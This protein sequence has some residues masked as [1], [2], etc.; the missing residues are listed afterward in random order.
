MSTTESPITYPEHHAAWLDAMGV[1]RWHSTH[2]IEPINVEISAP[3]SAIEVIKPITAPVKNTLPALIEHASYWVVGTEALD[4]ETAYLLAG[5]MA[6]IQATE[7]QVVYSHFGKAHSTHIA[8]GQVH[9]TKLHIEVIEN[10]TF[11]LPTQLKVLVL[12]DASFDAKHDAQWRIP[13]LSAMLETP[14]L[15]RDA[16]ETLKTMRAHNLP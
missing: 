9:F 15:K 8:T 11:E 1:S 6:A 3:I 13:S 4:H 16:W 14:Q 2:V 10:S 7:V 5:M 12:G